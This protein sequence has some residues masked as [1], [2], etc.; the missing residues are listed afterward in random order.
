MFRLP[1]LAGQTY[2]GLKG[3]QRYCATHCTL[4]Y[5]AQALITPLLQGTLVRRPAINRSRCGCQVLRH[6]LA[7]SYRQI[8]VPLHSSSLHTAA[9][10][11]DPDDYELYEESFDDDEYQE[12]CV[13]A[14]Y[15]SCI[16]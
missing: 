7:L 15:C 9:I 12:V 8:T 4:V 16:D 13:S 2:H 14:R 1:P 11:P 6:R 5:H 10:S 3:Q